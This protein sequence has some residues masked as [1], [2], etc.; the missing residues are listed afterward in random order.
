[1][2]QHAGHQGHVHTPATGG[3]GAESNPVCGMHVDPATTAGE[4]VHGDETYF[5]VPRVAV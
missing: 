3:K 1:M 2:S 4:V 5:S